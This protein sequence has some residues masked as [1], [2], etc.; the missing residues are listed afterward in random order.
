M[1][2]A[3]AIDPPVVGADDALDTELLSAASVASW[4]D[5]RLLDRQSRIAIR[6]RL[7][8]AQAAVLAAE[9]DRRSGRELGH[10]GLAARQGA[11]SPQ[12]LVQR[13][14]GGTAREARA[15]IEVGALLNGHAPDTAGP[16]T[17][18]APAVRPWLAVVVTAVSSGELGVEAAEAIRVGLGEPSATVTVEALA[19]AAVRLVGDARRTGADRLAARARQERDALDTA[20]V[21]DRERGR[22][23]QRFLKLVPQWDG[24]TRIIG[25][26]DPE[27]AALV[28]DAFDRVTAPRRGGPRFVDTADR[29]RAE[30]IAVDP[31]STDQLLHDAFVQMVDIAARADHMTVFGAHR[32]AVRVHVSMADLEARRGSGR[33][34]GQTDEVSIATV[35]R[36]VCDAG[37]IPIAFDTDGQVINVGRDQRNFTSRQRIGLAARDGGCVF[38]E[39]DRPPSWCE[40]HHI[41]EWLRDRGRTDIADGVLLCRFHHLLVHNQGWRIVREGAHYSAVPP[42][43]TGRDPVPLRAATAFR[44]E[45]RTPSAKRDSARGPGIDRHQAGDY[46]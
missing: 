35:E 13:I 5:E 21:A 4:S 29:A 25:L 11:R 41:D 10:Q 42:A 40:A 34:E 45:G 28:A 36:R 16:P 18:G 20:G 19:E 30:A 9:L 22:Y 15:L 24:M 3:V 6:R 38:G 1:V 12:E 23:E 26:L 7:L 46:S 33:L 14:T 27:S 17:P 37:I 8:D 32:V 43:G 2:L 44:A 39:C 31:R